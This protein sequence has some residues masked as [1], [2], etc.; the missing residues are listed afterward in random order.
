MRTL[1]ATV[2]GVYHLVKPIMAG[3]L[4]DPLITPAPLMRRDDTSDP[5]FL[6]YYFDTYISSW[7]RDLCSPYSGT[8]RTFTSS[9]NYYQCCAGSGRCV[10]NTAC[11]GSYL[12]DASG[13]YDCA[14]E[15][16]D[17][18]ATCTW[19]VMFS[20]GAATKA[21]SYIYCAGAGTAGTTYYRENPTSTTSTST[22]SSQTPPATPIPGKRNIKKR[23]S[24]LS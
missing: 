5:Y 12:I 11:S 24:A 8:I 14:T 9:A 1:L 2:Y 4:A 7:S 22:S 15:F 23:Q 10:M 21:Q 20:S 3:P 6:G 18:L 13:T 19:D 16:S 17:V